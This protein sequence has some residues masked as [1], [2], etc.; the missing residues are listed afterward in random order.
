MLFDLS[1]GKGLDGKVVMVTGATSGIGRATALLYEQVGS[2]VVAVGRNAE[3]LEK[4]RSEFR[5]PEEHLFLSADFQQSDKCQEVVDLTLKK[6]GSVFVLAHAAATLRRKSLWDVTEED[7]DYQI[8]VNL[9]STF[10]LNRAVSKV[11]ISQGIPGRIVNFTSG[12]WILGSLYGADAYA[13]SKAGIVTFSRGL[14]KQIGKYGIRVN[15]ISPGQ[16]NTPMQ[17]ND[18]TIENVQAV[19]ESCPLGRIG[20]PEEIASVVVFITSDHGSFIHGATINVSGG[21]LLY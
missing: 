14:A 20:E 2:R 17:H 8:S 18:N 13:T 7:W 9:K 21:T 10:L 16:I 3:L 12:S 15:T 1:I 11:M 19:T 6:Y 5:H 4:L